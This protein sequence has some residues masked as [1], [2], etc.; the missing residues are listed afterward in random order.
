MPNML[1]FTLPRTHQ[2][3][4]TV[5]QQESRV[6]VPATSIAT[7]APDAD[8][9]YVSMRHAETLRAFVQYSGLVTSAA[10]RLWL[11]QD[12]IWYRGASTALDPAGGNETVD[13]LIVGQYTQFMLQLSE[14]SGGGTAE[15]RVMGVW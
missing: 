11:L 6:L 12:G 13:L 7:A 10:L 1:A 15:L 14:I 5:V 2:H 8:T 4:E 9:P 3:D